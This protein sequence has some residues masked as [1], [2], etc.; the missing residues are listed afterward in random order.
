MLS[1]WISKIIK[2]WQMH[3]K[4]VK[5]TRLRSQWRSCLDESQ[6]IHYECLL[7]T[8][9]LLILHIYIHALIYLVFKHEMEDRSYYSKQKTFAWH[10]QTSLGHYAMD[11]HTLQKRL[12][13]N[14]DLSTHNLRFGHRSILD[15][16][17]F[18]FRSHPLFP[19]QI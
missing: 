12:S 4:W 10:T 1:I 5:H 8:W 14:L 16:R 19:T 6:R 18:F 11:S 7:I 13:S 15:C 3:M 17:C 2:H 9:S